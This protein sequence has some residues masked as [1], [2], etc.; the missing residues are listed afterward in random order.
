[1]TGFPFSYS[2]LILNF[3]PPSFPGFLLVF[4][5]VGFELYMIKTILLNLYPSLFSLPISFLFIYIYFLFSLFTYSFHLPSCL[6]PL[7]PPL[8]HHTGRSFVLSYFLSWPSLPYVFLPPHTLSDL[9]SDLHFRFHPFPCHLLIFS[10]LQLFSIYCRHCRLPAHHSLA[11]SAYP[12]A[13]LLHLFTAASLY[14]PPLPLPLPSR[15]LFL[16]YPPPPPI[17][18]T[19]LFPLTHRRCSLPAAP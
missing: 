15:L 4:C 14:H 18:S 1:M 13:Y 7:H 11:F 2:C 8:P 9:S 16:L 5:L 17:P 10:V 12:P 6:Y 19:R 3:P